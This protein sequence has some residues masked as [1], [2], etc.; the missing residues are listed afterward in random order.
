[1]AIAMISSNTFQ[2]Q[3]YW[4]I[5]QVFPNYAL[6]VSG[7]I[8]WVLGCCDSKLLNIIVSHLLKSVN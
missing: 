7:Y 1:M 5:K 6:K 3:C 8:F 2:F 4:E